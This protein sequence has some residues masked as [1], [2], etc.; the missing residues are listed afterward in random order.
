MQAMNGSS[1]P[2]PLQKALDDYHLMETELAAARQQVREVTVDNHTL[3]A[4]VN[5]LREELQ[6]A[7]ADR[8]R[9][10]AISS[11]LLGRLL[12]IN[13]T[14]GGAVR[15]SIKAGIEATAEVKPDPDLEKAGAE[16]QAILQRVVPMERT[17]A[18][19]PREVIPVTP[20]AAGAAIP[21]ID[22]HRLPQG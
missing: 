9:L 15:A 3:L 18:P 17:E 20:Q 13:D 16:A 22:W 8:L 21:A 4:E 6:R 19:V 5:M 7:D 2:N 1:E 11:T 10:Q 14:I 12:A